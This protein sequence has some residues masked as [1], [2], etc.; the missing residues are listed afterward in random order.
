MPWKLF[1]QLG[2][3]GGA[4]AGFIAPGDCSKL[5]L[6]PVTCVAIIKMKDLR[7][8]VLQ[9]REVLGFCEMAFRILMTDDTSDWLLDTATAAKE[10]KQTA[11]KWAPH[12]MSLRE[13]ILRTVPVMKKDTVRRL[14]DRYNVTEAEIFTSNPS[15]HNFGKGRITGV[16]EISIPWQ[17]ML[18][19]AKFGD[20]RWIGR[21]F[22]VPK[23]ETEARAI[24]NGRTLGTICKAPPPVF[25]PYLPDILRT[26]GEL[27]QTLPDGVTLFTADFRHFFHEVGV[28]DKL[29]SYFGVSIGGKY[30][31]WRS[32]V[33]GWQ[34]SPFC[35]QSV[36][37]SVLLHATQDLLRTRPDGEDPDFIIPK[38]LEKLPTTIELRNGGFITVYYDNLLIAGSKADVTRISERVRASCRAFD[39]EI[40]KGSDELKTP[41]EL[42]TSPLTFLGADLFYERARDG[43]LNFSWRQCEKRLQ[44]W[45]EA[46]LCDDPQSVPVWEKMWTRRELAAFIGRVLWRRSLY[47]HPKNGT[48]PII[49]LLRRIVKGNPGWDLRDVALTKEEQVM[50]SEAWADV[51]CNPPHRYND[52]PHPDRHMVLATDSSDR[53]YGYVLYDGLGNIVEEKGFVWDTDCGE[54]TFKWSKRHIYLK[55]LK[56]ALDIVGALSARYP[57]TVFDLGI[58]N[59]AA[60]AAIRHMYSGCLEACEWIDAFYAKL[61]K[62]GCSVNPWGLKSEDN[63]SDPASRRCDDPTVV[64]S[65]ELRLRCFERIQSQLKG[66]HTGPWTETEGLAGIVGIRHPEVL[67]VEEVD[68]GELVERIHSLSK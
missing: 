64:V 31:R 36:A 42:V 30:Y 6:D 66:Y 50:A 38:N 4:Y 21:Y 8:S 46:T 9:R 3:Y 12:I 26:V 57:E 47:Q 60:A 29:S 17:P 58:D 19:P 35:A 23:N 5:P 37:W 28:G 24:W 59:T 62:N 22:A 67:D 11:A 49:Q 39:V 44:T 13:E 41:H 54:K 10:D 51:L 15:L 55:E 20:L 65:D 61:L 18:L 16:P 34:W 1:R 53:G 48:A 63:A 2:L 32:L 27:S 40:K 68:P 25:L 52:I 14:A 33:M 56:C 43:T 45:R 7:G